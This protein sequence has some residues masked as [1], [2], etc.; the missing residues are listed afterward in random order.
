MLVI[1]TNQHTRPLFTHGQRSWHTAAHLLEMINGDNDDVNDRD[2]SP[3]GQ[4]CE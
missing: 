1:W 4:N 2:G 3:G